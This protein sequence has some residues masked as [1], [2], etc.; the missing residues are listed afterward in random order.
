MGCS[1]NVEKC[2]HLK[3]KEPSGDLKESEVPT[4]SV[5]R[6]FLVYSGEGLNQEED[7]RSVLEDDSAGS[8]RM[9]GSSKTRGSDRQSLK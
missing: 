3:L 2:H 4:G 9:D 8:G 6:A 1:E 7:I 5:C